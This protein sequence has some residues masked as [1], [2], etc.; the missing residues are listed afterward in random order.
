MKKTQV[1]LLTLFSFIGILMLVN[2]IINFEGTSL[3]QLLFWMFIAGLCE[4]LP[5][6]FARNRVVTVTLAVL[7]T[8][9]LSHGTYF[10]T[11]VAASA[12]IF[13]LIKL[14]TEAQAYI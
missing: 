2:C 13:Y 11:L 4:S 14:R 12:A 9:Q 3:Y 8:L 1:L 6:Y 10:T 5:V 7:L